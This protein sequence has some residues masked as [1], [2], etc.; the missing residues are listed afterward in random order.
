MAGAKV[1]AVAVVGDAIPVVAAALLPGAVIGLPVL[2][3][4]LLPCA[5]PDLLL[6]L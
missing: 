2:R 1:S 4:V 5:L 6:M 3:A